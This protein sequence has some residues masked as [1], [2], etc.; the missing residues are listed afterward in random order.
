MIAGAA[1]LAV[2][3]TRELAG[4]RLKSRSRGCD[5]CQERIVNLPNGLIAA[6]LGPLTVGD[7]INGH[8]RET[9]LVLGGADAFRDTIVGWGVPTEWAAELAQQIENHALRTLYEERPPPMPTGFQAM[10]A[11]A[12]VR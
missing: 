6:A 1:E 8:T 10:V 2:A 3:R 4:S 5:E 12:V 9:S 7:V 11:R